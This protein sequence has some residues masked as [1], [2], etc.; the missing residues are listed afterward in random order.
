MPTV[1]LQQVSSAFAR[2]NAARTLEKPIGLK[3]IERYLEP[4]QRKRLEPLAVSGLR[5]WGAKRERAHQFLKIV[6]R[7]SLVLFRRGKNVF[8]IGVVAEVAINEKLAES[9][10][11][12]DEDGETW[13]LIF[14]LRRVVPAQWAAS[15]WNHILGRSAVDNWQGMAV[16]YVPDFPELERFL[17][18]LF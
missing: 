14:F 11:S 3:F 2:R 15:E 4:E 8:A 12:R 10:W 13:P 7:E 5:V 9:L 18:S 17:G 6:P 16:E 1:V